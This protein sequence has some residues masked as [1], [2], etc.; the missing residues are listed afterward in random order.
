VRSVLRDL[1]GQ[2]FN[3][4]TV[5]S[6]AK[7]CKD[8][9]GQQRTHWLCKCACGNI[10]E[11]YTNSLTSGKSTSCGCTKRKLSYGQSAKHTT[12]TSYKGTAKRKGLCFELNETQ[13]TYI[14]QQEC[15]YCGKLPSNIAKGKKKY[16]EWIYNG[17]D[18]LDNLIGYKLDN[19]VPCCKNCNLAKRSLTEKQFLSLVKAIYERHLK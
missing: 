14:T 19:V 13:F 5:L 2:K 9:S 4:W 6:F 1:T 3:R 17:I 7:F 18:R 16:G 8:K 15:Y 12:F 10:K 11:V